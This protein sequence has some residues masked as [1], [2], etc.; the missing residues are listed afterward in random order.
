MKKFFAAVF[1]VL[2]IFFLAHTEASDSPNTLVEKGSKAK[3]K[4]EIQGH[5]LPGKP[6]CSGKPHHPGKPHCPEKPTPPEVCPPVHATVAYTN[7]SPPWISTKEILVPLDFIE[8]ANGITLDET[9]STLTLQKGVYALQFQFA[10]VTKDLGLNGIDE[11]QIT[12]V[13]LDIDNDSLRIP[14]DWVMSIDV[15]S[16]LIQNAWGVFSGSKLFSIDADNTLVKFMLFRDFP[17]SN[18]AGTVQVKFS[19]YQ[20]SAVQTS[21]NNAVRVSLHRIGDCN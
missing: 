14:L 19:V 6:H 2:S 21:N 4:A 3:A 8:I 1:A 13:Y 9:T 5:C 15:S 18:N 7:P 12:D 16:D 11:L 17:E 20:N 10:L